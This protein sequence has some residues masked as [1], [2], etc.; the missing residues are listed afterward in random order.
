[1]FCSGSN[2]VQRVRAENGALK[3]A[4]EQLR[5]TAM[6]GLDIS[7][8]PSEDTK[9][10]CLSGNH[11]PPSPCTAPAMLTI[12]AQ[13]AWSITSGFGFD[14]PKCLGGGQGDWLC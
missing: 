1:M 6:D 10:R 5:R 9:V 11:K 3:D 4:L 14:K 13:H 8:Q 7:T 12:W 2:E